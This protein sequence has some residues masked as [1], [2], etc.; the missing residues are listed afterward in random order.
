M[1][2]GI[3]VDVVAGCIIKFKADTTNSGGYLKFNCQV[4]YPSTLDPFLPPELK[5]QTD[6]KDSV[7]MAFS[8]GQGG[9]V[10]GTLEQAESLEAELKSKIQ[11]A[12]EFSPRAV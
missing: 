3:E 11:S 7:I 4:D 8:G 6:W 1:L 12:R 5:K 9:F 2:Q 10:A